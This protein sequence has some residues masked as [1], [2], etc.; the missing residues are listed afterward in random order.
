MAGLRPDRAVRK[1]LR[2]GHLVARFRQS[3]R[4]PGGRSSG[5]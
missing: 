2:R 1:C 3:R 4:P 5:L